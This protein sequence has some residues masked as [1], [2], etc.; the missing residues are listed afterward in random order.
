MFKRPT[1]FRSSKIKEKPKPTKKQANLQKHQ[2]YKK[3]SIKITSDFSETMQKTEQNILKMER[4]QNQPRTLYPTKLAFNTE[5]DIRKQQKKK[6]EEICCQQTC[7]SRNIERSFS[8]ENYI[9]QK[10]ESIKSE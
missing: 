2:I 4:K 9:H 6:I 8:E 3:A 7:L 5:K 10:L 1:K